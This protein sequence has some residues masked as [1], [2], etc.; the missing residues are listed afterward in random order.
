MRGV[1]QISRDGNI[2]LENDKNEVSTYERDFRIPLLIVSA[3]LFV[4]DVIVRKFKWK[5][6]QGLFARKSKEVKSK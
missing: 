4:I 3:V 6:I 5:D 2:N 1:G